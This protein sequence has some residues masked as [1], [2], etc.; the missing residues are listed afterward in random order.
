MLHCRYKTEDPQLLTKVW[1][2]FRLYDSLS[3][4]LV[5]FQHELNPLIWDLRRCVK[6]GLGDFVWR[7][8]ELFG[9][10]FRFHLCLGEGLAL[11]L[12]THLIERRDNVVNG[13]TLDGLIEGVKEDLEVEE[14]RIQM[15]WPDIKVV[16][17]R[18]PLLKHVMRWDVILLFVAL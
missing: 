3:F 16:S 10:G 7:Y 9:D 15:L 12:H 13:S 18:Y 11:D 14:G 8:P 17:V 2:D 1:I 4:L 6:E 5:G